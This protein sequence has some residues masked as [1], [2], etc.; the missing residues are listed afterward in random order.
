[1]LYIIFARG[2][3][4]ALN[5]CNTMIYKFDLDS[6]YPRFEV[7]GKVTGTIINQFAMDE[8]NG[9]FRIATVDGY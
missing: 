4:D 7:R 5:I 6:A 9:Y 2:R 8:H 1:M 3:F